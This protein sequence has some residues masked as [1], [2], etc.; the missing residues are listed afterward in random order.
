MPHLFTNRARTGLG[1]NTIAGA[2][3]L[4][5]FKDLKEEESC[6][7]VKDLDKGFGGRRNN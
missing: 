7:L 6:F 3:A 2:G 5:S 4:A 1:T